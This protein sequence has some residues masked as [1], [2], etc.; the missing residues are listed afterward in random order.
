MTLKRVVAASSVLV[1]VIAC[2]LSYALNVVWSNAG[3][4]VEAQ[5]KRMESL[6]LAGELQQSSENLTNFV[7]LYVVTADEAYAEAY[8]NVVKMVNGDRER[9]ADDRVAP[10]KKIS[11]N[12][13]MGQAGFTTEELALLQEAGELSLALVALEEE[14]M[15][16]VR[17]LY[18]DASGNYTVKKEADKALAARLVFG[19]D[20]ENSIEKIMR[21]IGDFQ[22]KLNARLDAALQGAETG[23]NTA[24]LIL[25]GLSVAIMG[26]MVLYLVLLNLYIVKPILRCNAFAVRV[27]G[28]DF[29]SAL[30]YS[31]SNEIGSLADSLKSMVT[32]L[33]ERI[34]LAEDS[35]AK[36]EAQSALAV[37]AT[38]EAE[39]AK[40]AAEKAK[41]E[42]MRQAGDRLLAVVERA[43]QTSSALSGQIRRATEGAESQQRRLT[44][45]A[46]AMDQL[47]QVVM[48]V[49]RNTSSTT[50]SA[51][52][53]GKTAATGSEIVN[54]VVEAIS[55]VD[56]KAGSLRLGLGQLGEKAEGIGKIMSVI[57][58]IADQTN[59]LALNAAIEAAR[60]GEAGRG[61]A[62]VADE[63]RKLAEKTMSATKEVGE[64]VRGIQS[65]TTDNIRGMDE[66][67]KAVAVGTE[68]ANAAGASLAEIVGL[69]NATAERIRSIAVAAEEQSSTCEEITKTTESIHQTAGE[70]LVI[71]E[72]AGR[73]VAEI[74]AVVAEVTA[75]TEQLRKA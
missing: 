3:G 33:R 37:Q 27:A 44:E 59:L 75:L 51:T 22:Q 23:F 73:G 30:E 16:A 43:K 68:L 48:E 47:N 21:P 14:A 56:K 53:T 72:E 40:A 67:S 58:D 55:E 46:Q 49:A 54:K 71:M 74:N 42:G 6:L 5:N 9:P 15:N 36:A 63:V 35:T 61:F 17:G 26:G 24:L 18:R 10:G 11:L 39:A 34:A 38:R 70:T 2:I 4:M 52:A 65:G 29:G 20:Y 12:A 45:A 13:L 62:V 7:R 60:A 1:L 57:S 31:S 8:W 25:A 19:K 28:G 69:V 50:D 66:A 32:A 41:S 64:A